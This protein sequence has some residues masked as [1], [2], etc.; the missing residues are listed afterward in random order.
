M[1]ETLDRFIGEVREIVKEGGT[2]QVLR[3]RTARA[4][5]EG[6]ATVF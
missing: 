2:N 4:Y 3:L 1:P 5:A 6:R